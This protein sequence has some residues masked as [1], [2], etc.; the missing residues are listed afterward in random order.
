MTRAGSRRAWRRWRRRATRWA[1]PP[2]PLR[3]RRGGFAAAN[4]ELRGAGAGAAGGQ[5]RVPDATKRNYATKKTARETA[6]PAAVVESNASKARGPD[7]GARARA[8]ARRGGGRSR[9]SAC[10]S[11]ARAARR[12][13]PRPPPPPPARRRARSAAVINEAA[14]APPR[15]SCGGR[16]DGD[17]ARGV[18]A[19]RRLSTGRR[20]VSRGD[21]P[22]SPTGLVPAF[23]A[24]DPDDAGTTNDE[25]NASATSCSPAD[26]GTNA[27][28]SLGS[29]GTPHSSSSSENARER[30]V[31]LRVP[32]SSPARVRAGGV[33]GGKRPG[34]AD[35]KQAQARRGEAPRVETGAASP[36]SSTHARLAA[37]PRRCGE[38]ETSRRARRKARTPSRA[39]GRGGARASP[40]TR[41]RRRRLRR[42]RWRR[43]RRPPSCRAPAGLPHAEEVEKV[44]RPENGRSVRGG[45]TG[46]G[47]GCVDAANRRGARRRRDRRASR[48]SSGTR[49]GGRESRQLFAFLPDLTRKAGTTSDTDAARG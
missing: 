7:R 11:A 37:A 13:A 21:A 28:A 6:S 48:F 34:S 30:C 20:R 14:P 36:P 25:L 42:S 19:R 49:R 24:K 4:Q 38:A 10:A 9:C 39:G 35:R 15:L 33:R 47:A 8:R 40:R 29:S 46:A 41:R 17:R 12:V 1:A 26:A 2:P 43:R 23:D 31:F 44:L 16:A 18:R 22:N 45:A 32:G 5:R 27:D 3:R